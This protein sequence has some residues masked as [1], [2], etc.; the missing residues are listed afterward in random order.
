MDDRGHL[1][2]LLDEQAVGLG[3]AAERSLADGDVDTPARLAWEL[4]LAPLRPGGS[5][6]ALKALPVVI[7]GGLT[8]VPGAIVGGLIMG[9]TYAARVF[10]S[11]NLALVV[12]G[13]VIA[14]LSSDG[15]D[16]AKK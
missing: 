4:W 2:V 9:G 5:W 7:L 12:L 11:D 6:V 14:A 15:A 10:L 13:S 8:S 1:A 16:K 3:A